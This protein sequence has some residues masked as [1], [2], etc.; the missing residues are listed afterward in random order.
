MKWKLAV[1]PKARLDLLEAREWYEQQRAGLG[2][3]FADEVQITLARIQQSPEIFRIVYRHYR[4]A[5]TKRFPYRIFYSVDKSNVF[6]LRV[7]H[8][9]RDHVSE[10]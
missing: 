7:L 1:D 4:Q 10:L 5:L 3:E 2:D 8:T 9:S 6:V